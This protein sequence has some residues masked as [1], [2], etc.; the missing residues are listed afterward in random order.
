MQE[1]N[2]LASLF[3]KQGIAI[4]TEKCY[5]IYPRIMTMEGGTEQSYQGGAGWWRL[6]PGP[7]HSR[8]PGYQ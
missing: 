8:G 6:V 3:T 1:E 4:K 5:Q 2:D 7:G